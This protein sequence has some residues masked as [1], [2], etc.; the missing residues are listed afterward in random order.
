MYR[1]FLKFQLDKLGVGGHYVSLSKQ[2]SECLHI[3]EVVD[4]FGCDLEEI[5]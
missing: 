2:L 4:I 3:I 5:P 1:K